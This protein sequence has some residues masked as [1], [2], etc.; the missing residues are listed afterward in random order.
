[1]AVFN[2]RRRPVA[3]SVRANP[4]S[5]WA[6]IRSLRVSGASSAVSRRYLFGSES[7]AMVRHV[8]PYCSRN[9]PVVY[10]RSYLSQTARTRTAISESR[11]SAGPDRVVLDLIAQ[12][13]A[14]K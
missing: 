2:P 14:H 11:F 1:M 4:G 10:G 5:S 9:E 13:A 7:L 3:G 8:S 6:N 12:V